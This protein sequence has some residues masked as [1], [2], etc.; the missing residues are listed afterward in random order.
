MEEGK[1]VLDHK[2]V[3]LIDVINQT[4]LKLQGYAHQQNVTINP[5]L[6]VPVPTIVG[7]SQRL[8]Q[9]LTNLIGNA[10]KFSPPNESVSIAAFLDDTEVLIQIK[11][12]GIGIPEDALE[13]IFSRYYQVHN[14]NQRSAMG[15]GLG[16]HIA[17]Q[18]VEGHGGRIWAESVEQQG[19]TFCFTLPLPT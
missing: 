18:I 11:D 2:P 19:S 1:L 8:E 4:I 12:N 16:L 6:S 5:D 7:D 17:K 13:T 14:K 9:V 3:S 10:I 15:T